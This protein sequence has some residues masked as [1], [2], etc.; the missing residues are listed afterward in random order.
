M[1]KHMGHEWPTRHIWAFIG[2]VF[3]CAFPVEPEFFQ[4]IAK[5]YLL[6]P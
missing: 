5:T 2:V 4:D 6:N 3:V 1:R